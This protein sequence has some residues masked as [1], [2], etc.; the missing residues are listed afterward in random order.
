MSLKVIIVHGS[1]SGKS[2]VSTDKLVTVEARVLRNTHQ[3]SAGKT[4]QVNLPNVEAI[5]QFLIIHL[6]TVYLFLILLVLI[7][8]I[9]IYLGMLISMVRT[10]L[11]IQV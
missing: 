6:T 4:S 5:C 8:L 10:R 2:G 9:A 7:A 11:G 1:M 3:K